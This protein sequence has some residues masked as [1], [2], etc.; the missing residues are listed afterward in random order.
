MVEKHASQDAVVLVQEFDV[1]ITEPLQQPRGA[2]DIGEEERDR[3]GVQVGHAPISL[4]PCRNSN[5]AWRD[6]FGP[7]LTRDSSWVKQPA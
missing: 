7:V 5:E 1:A 3:V 6:P 4:K 2:L